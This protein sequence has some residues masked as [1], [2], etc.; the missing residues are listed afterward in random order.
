ML[1]WQLRQVRSAEPAVREQAVRSLA[2]RTDAQARTAVLEAHRDG[3]ER[4]RLAVAEVLGQH[5]SPEG[6]RVLRTQLKD[7]SAAVR[8]AA[9]ASLDARA[10]TDVEGRALWAFARDSREDVL[11]LGTGAIPFIAPF[12]ASA[13]RATRD[14]AKDLL[15]RIEYPRD[16][17]SLLGRSRE[18][19]L[20]PAR[21]VDALRVRLDESGDA[22]VD[23]LARVVQA[24]PDDWGVLGFAM[25]VLERLGPRGLP[26][27]VVIAHRLEYRRSSECAQV[28]EAIGR[29]GAPAASQL[30]A[31]LD[32]AAAEGGGLVY[33]VL[34]RM[35]EVAVPA[36]VAALE[37]S[38]KHVRQFAAEFL[39]DVRWQPTGPRQVA[40]HALAGET[41]EF[42]HARRTR[43]VWLEGLRK[44]PEDAV[45]EIGAL[46]RDLRF[47][48]R[49]GASRVLAILDQPMID[50]IGDPDPA[51]ATVAMSASGTRRD[52]RAI[53][54]LLLG[55]A[56]GD[57]GIRGAAA[58]AL[59]EIGTE[60]VVAPLIA[61]FGQGLEDAAQALYVVQ[62]DRRIG[63]ALAARIA[64]V[65]EPHRRAAESDRVAA[66]NQQVLEL[67]AE[68][69]KYQELGN[70]PS[71][72]FHDPRMS[73]GV[74][75]YRLEQLLETDAARLS[76]EAL[77][78][79]TTLG[80]LFE[81]VQREVSD[82]IR[83]FTEPVD[84]SAVRRHAGR[85]LD[86]R[87]ARD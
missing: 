58:R 72:S 39:D 4:V 79:I 60:A 48:N 40:L 84:L 67:L 7:V 86:R 17:A 25:G 33:R 37:S 28:E 16:M 66:V 47:A 46:A 69:G 10:P 56:E 8:A 41:G 11:A 27:L 61:A 74:T 20:E 29:L 62:D 50:L 30:L 68:I 13:D 44:L 19:W 3:V 73:A 55:L 24:L 87:S 32:V 57:P 9:A 53:D 71:M 34:R 42:D 78:R 22:G 83:L 26:G 85:E 64:T 35:K 52:E 14:R 21:V 45:R 54:A 81:Q 80:V 75:V 63:P 77:G 18:L 1:W 70:E 59:G 43:A 36:A 2:G 5:P 51:V 82:D 49:A 12:L 6:D 76:S 23:E 15:G 31:T 65:L 38:E